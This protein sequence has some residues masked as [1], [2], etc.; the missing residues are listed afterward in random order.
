M[1]PRCQNIRGRGRFLQRGN[2]MAE[3]TCSIEDCD[4]TLHA[5]DLCA[6]HY[7]RRWKENRSRSVCSVRGCSAL[8][9]GRG[10]C[11]KHYQRLINN[12]PLL[13]DVSV[14]ERFFRKVIVEAS[15]CLIWQ[16]LKFS[17]GYGRF[18][19]SKSNNNP[20][21]H[22]W[23]YVRFRGPIPVGFVLDHLCRVKECVNPWHLEI[24]TPKEN[25]RR[26]L[27]G[28]MTHCRR[29]HELTP[30]NTGRQKN[31]RYCRQCANERSRRNS[32]RYRERKRQL[33]LV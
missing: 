9:V 31:G 24:V 16:G 2:D 32:P 23:A 19:H 7:N 14:D 13:L 21:A 30:E 8:A 28:E 20:G 27:W 26:G 12:R 11:S 5:K 15:G 29:G 17:N 1:P 18:D 4:K 25:V 3:R 33:R 22:R 6:T 10:M